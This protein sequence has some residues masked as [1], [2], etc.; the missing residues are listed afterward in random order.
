[1]IPAVAKSR[2]TD[3]SPERLSAQEER[4]RANLDAWIE[5]SGY[6]ATQVADLAGIPQASLARWLAGKHAIPYGA[7]RPLADALG[8]ESIEEFEM[9]SPPRQRTKEELA[10]LMPVLGKHRPGAEPTKEDLDDYREYLRRVQS[11]REKKKPKS[12]Q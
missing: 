9:P 6:T 5:A 4:A 10:L 8:R 2:E 7:L 12:S 11:R 3:E 1:M